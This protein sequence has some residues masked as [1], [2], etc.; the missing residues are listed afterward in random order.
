MG[1][2]QLHVG[3]EWVYFVFAIVNF[4]EF[5]GYLFSRESVYN[6]SQQESA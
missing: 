3:T 6:K 5:V 2:V 4:G 1:F